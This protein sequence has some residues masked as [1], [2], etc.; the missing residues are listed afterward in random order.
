MFLTSLRA[1]KKRRGATLTELMVAATVFSLMALTL[2]GLLTYGSQSYKKIESRYRMEMQ[3]QRA[4]FRMDSDLR[5]TNI[6]GFSCGNRSGGRGIDWMAF[7]TAVYPQADV[8]GYESA[9]FDKNYEN[10]FRRDETGKLVW[11]YYVIYYLE[12]HSSET[13]PHP[14][15]GAK[16]LCSVYVPVKNKY[17]TGAGVPESGVLTSDMVSA[18][19]SNTRASS[20][21]IL[22][23]DIIYWDVSY[24]A[25]GESTER[26]YADGAV[27]APPVDSE[28]ADLDKR[29][30]PNSIRYTLIGIKTFEVLSKTSATNVQE[31]LRDLSA[32]EGLSPEKAARIKRYTV[33]FSNT[34]FPSNSD[35]NNYKNIL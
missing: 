31:F 12:D 13:S 16:R 7:K 11:S 2:V 8:A 10:K 18:W 21:Q 32:D 4:V 6:F 3:I 14:I 15:S 26:Y 23:D 5:N 35:E 29:V 28:L 25:K 17:N 19:L 33:Q 30:V 24:Y 1:K 20:K 27:T 22:A 9:V 34:V